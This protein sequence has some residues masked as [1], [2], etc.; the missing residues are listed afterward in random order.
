MDFEQ[1]FNFSSQN[2]LKSNKNFIRSNFT[3]KLKNVDSN[4]AL[5]NKKNKDLYR[6]DTENNNSYGSLTEI[7]E[8]IYEI[9]NSSESHHEE[10]FDIKISDDNQKHIYSSSSLESIDINS[11]SM[12]EKS[13]KSIDSNNSKYE[14]LKIDEYGFIINDVFHKKTY[15]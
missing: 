1:T 12:S 10:L 5:K 3:K 9:S 2:E 6:K 7:T 8:H 4:Y 14:K 11:D 13:D 15:K